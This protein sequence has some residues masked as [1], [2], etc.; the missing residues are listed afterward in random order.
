MWTISFAKPRKCAVWQHAQH[1]RRIERVSPRS[2]ER[3]ASGAHASRWCK[4]GNL[5]VERPPALRHQRQ[6]L[7]VSYRRRPNEAGGLEGPLHPDHVPAH[8]GDCQS[9]GHA[10][11]A[12]RARSR[13]RSRR[14]HL[15]P[16]RHDQI[17]RQSARRA[18]PAVD[19]FSLYL[20]PVAFRVP[21]P[22]GG[23]GVSPIS[24]TDITGDTPFIPLRSYSSRTCS[25][26]SGGVRHPAQRVLNQ[27]LSRRCR[28]RHAHRL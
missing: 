8:P 12:H 27:D 1:H 19:R 20:R 3:L 2:R 13:P 22:S 18:V 9:V 4:V 21:G 11:M 28:I 25:C 16:R 14:A 23:T 24:Q 17:V 5:L 10:T 7:A 15:L 26:F 6:N